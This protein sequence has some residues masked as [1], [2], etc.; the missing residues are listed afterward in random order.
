MIFEKLVI[1][2]LNQSYN[3]E[4]KNCDF[5]LLNRGYIKINNGK[6]ISLSSL[7][8]LYFNK[9]KKAFLETYSKKIKD[10]R[11]KIPFFSEIETFNLRNDKNKSIDLILNIL[12]INEYIKKKN[13]KYIE[14]ITDNEDDCVIFNQL[15]SK[16]K[17]TNLNIEKNHLQFYF[18]KLTKFYFKVFIILV[19]LKFYDKKNIIKNKI[20]KICLSIYPIFYSRN[21]ENFF[22]N[23]NFLKLNFLIS[24]ETHLNHS[25]VD[26]L[27]VIKK[28]KKNDLIH[29]ESLINFSDLFL[30]YLKGTYRLNRIHHTDLELNINKIN[31][32]AYFEKDFLISYLN[33][34]KLEIYTNPLNNIF[35]KSNIKQFHYYLFEYNFGI[36]LNN[37]IKKSNKKIFTI[38]YQHGIFT[39][40]IFWMDLLKKF[41]SNFYLPNKIIYFS[42]IS[43]KAYKKVFTK[44][45]FEYKKKIPS[46]ISTQI[47]IKKNNLSIKKILILP[48][49]HDAKDILFAINKLNK[50]YRNN[51]KYFIKFHPKMDLKMKS[52]VNLIKI[53]KIK[54]DEFDDV[55]ISQT[56]TLMYDFIHLNKKFKLMHLDY[57]N[58]LVNINDNKYLKY[59]SITE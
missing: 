50:N 34:L 23:K 39:Q 33:R 6:K 31:F 20:D 15:S 40:N 44:Q 56:S 59:F 12:V 4:Y 28:C 38:G 22:N 47:K 35:K 51:V 14:L 8:K 53:K 54:L 2:N 1:I 21:I 26:I 27:N 41:K 25:I 30:S 24:D 48:G 49:T 5:I 17:I 46:N 52:S 58:N 16:I 37:L 57:K 9:I 10:L 36:F 7:K 42:K 29:A 19:L 43:L 11:I 18:L 45:K 32:K 13:F 3:F 55:L